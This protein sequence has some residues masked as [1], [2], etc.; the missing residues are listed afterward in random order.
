MNTEYTRKHQS[1]PL[2]V[3]NVS[4]HRHHSPLLK[5]SSVS[6]GSL[7][8]IIK[9]PLVTEKSVRQNAHSTYTFAVDK[10]ATKR[11]IALA[12]KEIYAVKVTSVNVAC[13]QGKK[14][15]SKGR[16]GVRAHTKKA[17][18]RFEKSIDVFVMPS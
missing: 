1:I 10:N 9:R 4:T 3:R 7:F 6:S 8:D 12:L 18:V 15:R 14:K 11:D 16:I 17:F 13:A 5:R 2:D